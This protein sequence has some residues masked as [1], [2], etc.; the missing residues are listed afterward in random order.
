MN[1]FITQLYAQHNISQPSVQL[2]AL[3]YPST[4][5]FKNWVVSSFF[6][7]QLI[8]GSFVFQFQKQRK[9]LQPKTI[10]FH[11]KVILT[12]ENWKKLNTTNF[13]KRLIV[14]SLVS[15]CDNLCYGITDKLP[16][17]IH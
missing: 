4:S 17:I 10:Y 11:K 15:P 12:Y 8:F 13:N 5:H 9:Q 7:Q 14:I 16:T 1:K 6:T 3:S 2:H